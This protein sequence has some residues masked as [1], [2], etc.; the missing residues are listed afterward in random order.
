[1]KKI[2][3]VREHE[4]APF[5][6]KSLR[7]EGG[8]RIAVAFWG[9]GALELLGLKAG[10]DLQIICNLAHPG[11]NP[12]VI[13]ELTRLKIKV[14]SNPRLHAKI[15]VT[16]TLGIVGS[17]NASS[18]GLAVEDGPALGWLEANVA[19]TAP[20]FVDDVK[21]R[22]KEIMD[23]AGTTLVRPADIGR[24]K[25]QRLKLPPAIFGLR[26]GQSLFEAA[27]AYPDAFASV[28]VA[29]YNQGLDAEA[30]SLV[31]GVTADIS[32]KQGAAAA[33]KVDG[34]QF[35]DMP[36]DAWLIDLSCYEGKT[37]TYGGTA[38][39]FGDPIKVFKEGTRKPLNDLTLAL[40]DKIVIGGHRFPL[41]KAERALLVD[42]APALLRAARARLL[43]LHR[44]LAIIDRKR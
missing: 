36:R 9:R 12:F 17:S 22:F 24:A 8:A 16:E 14:W 15:Y 30:E 21:A 4:L 35:K 10:Q 13:E 3:I 25:E 6:R 28:F 29:V 20:S 7:K 41:S 34:Y 32:R 38:R 1:V 2:D 40:R 39:T 43:P 42:A 26:A 37:P 33:D 31:D 5:F 18:N 27:R 19:G 23:D 11:C 44:A